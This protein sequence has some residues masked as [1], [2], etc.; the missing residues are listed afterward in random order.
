MDNKSRENATMFIGGMSMLVAIFLLFGS[1]N[2]DVLLIPLGFALVAISIIWGSAIVE[3]MVTPKY[4][5]PP[6]ANREDTTA[7]KLAMFM[8]LM[9]TDERE[10]FKNRL[11][12]SLINDDDSVS[13][14]S[15]IAE[16]RKRG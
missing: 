5:P 2:A 7:Y 15:L 14:E 12:D 6:Q 1:G 11:A 9:D 4:Y 3:A 16:K 13:I 10:I 8:E